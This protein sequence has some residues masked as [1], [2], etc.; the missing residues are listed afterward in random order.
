MEENIQNIFLKKL[1][2]KIY[3]VIIIIIFDFLSQLDN[4]ENYQSNT[5]KLGMMNQKN[6]WMNKDY[7]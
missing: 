6:H 1:S 2:P 4:L 3:R 5:G 7:L